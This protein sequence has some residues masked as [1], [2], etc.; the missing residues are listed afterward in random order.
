MRQHGGGEVPK[1]LSTKSYCGYYTMP[2]PLLQQV[3]FKFYIYFA[4]EM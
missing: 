3:F 2:I 4:T 1:D